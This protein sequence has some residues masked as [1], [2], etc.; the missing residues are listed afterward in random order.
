[1]GHH[2]EQHVQKKTMIQRNLFHTLNSMFWACPMF[3]Q[4]QYSSSEIDF[5]GYLKKTRI[6]AIVIKILIWLDDKF[7]HALKS[8][9]IRSIGVTASIEPPGNEPGKSPIP[10]GNEPWK[11][12]IHH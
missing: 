12:N 1:M 10:S 3:G 9:A 6:P 4:N 5:D 7:Q 11:W 8:R 2:P